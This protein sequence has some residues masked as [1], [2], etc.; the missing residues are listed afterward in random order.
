MIDYIKTVNRGVDKLGKYWLV[1]YSWE[2]GGKEFALGSSRFYEDY[3]PEK[4]HV[5][6]VSEVTLKTIVAGMYQNK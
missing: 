2:V 6:H 4:D 5:E 1:M 3:L